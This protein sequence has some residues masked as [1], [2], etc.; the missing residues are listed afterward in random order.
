MQ[1]LT[2]FKCRCGFYKAKLFNFYKCHSLS[3]IKMKLQNIC[4]IAVLKFIY[5]YCVTEMKTNEVNLIDCMIG[6]EI[7]C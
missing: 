1:G 2:F 3:K 4:C 6:K 5:E 7:R